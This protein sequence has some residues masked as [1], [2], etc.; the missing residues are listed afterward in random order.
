MQD[1][2][3]QGLPIYL[4]MLHTFRQNIASGK[5]PP[6]MRVPPVR[7]LSIML[8]V[9]PNT[10]QRSLLEL[11][12]EGLAYTERTTGRFITNDTGRIQAMRRELAQEYTGM[13]VR[14]MQALGFDD[15][16]ILDCVQRRKQQKEANK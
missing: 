10:A 14:Q 8:E 12:R 1:N 16:E 15:T 9:N 13:Y 5:W 6:G 7:E 3:L 4:Q 11:E 2:Y